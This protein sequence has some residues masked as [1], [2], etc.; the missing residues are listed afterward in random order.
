MGVALRHRI[1]PIKFIGN[2]QSFKR[3]VLVKISPTWTKGDREIHCE[4]KLLDLQISIS[5]RKELLGCKYFVSYKGVA[6]KEA[7]GIGEPNLRA[8]T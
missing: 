6:K 7:R 5:R 4:K 1:N 8:C 2:P 3:I